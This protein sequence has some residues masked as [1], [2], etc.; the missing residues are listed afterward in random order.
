MTFVFDHH[1]FGILLPVHLLLVLHLHV[2]LVL[3]LRHFVL[4]LLVELHLFV[5][6][7]LL[8]RLHRLEVADFLLQH[9]IDQVV[10][11]FQLNHCVLFFLERLHD[12]H[13]LGLLHIQLLLYL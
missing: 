4:H 1:F 11:I 13:Y 8:V 5:L 3:L 2:V 12:H 6:V 9:F 10:L 7:L